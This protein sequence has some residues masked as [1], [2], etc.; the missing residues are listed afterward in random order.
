M[1]RPK[2]LQR[3]SLTVPVVRLATD[4]QFDL[5]SPRYYD[6]VWRKSVELAIQ[7]T[8][9]DMLYE[10]SQVNLTNSVA[11]AL[12]MLVE[13]VRSPATTDAQAKEFASRAKLWSTLVTSNHDACMSAI[14]G[15]S[16]SEVRET[17]DEA[18]LSKADKAKQAWE[19]IFGKRGDPK[20]EAKVVQ[21]TQ[22]FQKMIAAAAEDKQKNKR[23]AK[24]KR[25]RRR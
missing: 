6:P 12:A 3:D 21:T 14:T 22:I 2:F 19:K 16:R 5:R 13:S 7:K 25:R 11:S 23:P 18:Q 17:A 4:R 15:N 1:V 24:E 20:T 8:Q 10:V 9:R